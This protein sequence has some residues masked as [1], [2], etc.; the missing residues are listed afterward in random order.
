VDDVLVVEVHEALAGLGENVST[1]LVN[2][3]FPNIPRSR[4]SQS[5]P[6]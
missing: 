1:S 4:W 3:N 6:L 2:S 5:G